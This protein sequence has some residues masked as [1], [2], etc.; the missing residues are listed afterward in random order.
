VW[1]RASAAV[2]SPRVF[3]FAFVGTC[4]LGLADV[5]DKAVYQA[6]QAIDH[7]GRTGELTSG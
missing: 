5:I 2:C 6:A 4:G 3:T 1:R 7:Y